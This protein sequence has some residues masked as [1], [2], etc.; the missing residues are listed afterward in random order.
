[1]REWL[2][3]GWV[4]E[5]LH[6]SLINQFLVSIEKKND[7]VNLENISLFNKLGD[8]YSCRVAFFMEIVWPPCLEILLEIIDMPLLWQ[9]TSVSVSC[10]NQKF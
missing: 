2:H 3:C 6:I 7:S 4:R 5:W 8:T 10:Q 9:D 1:M